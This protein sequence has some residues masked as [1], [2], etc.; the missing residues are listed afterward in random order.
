MLC[1][2]QEYKITTNDIYLDYL[3]L[4]NSDIFK[5]IILSGKHIS[6]KLYCTFSSYNNID[7]L[8]YDNELSVYHNI[9]NE[10]IIDLIQCSINLQKLT[11]Y[12]SHI[13]SNQCKK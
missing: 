1:K 4:E 11:I 3:T 12:F 8:S 7:I 9:T 2:H 6:V 10:N 5:K 13:F